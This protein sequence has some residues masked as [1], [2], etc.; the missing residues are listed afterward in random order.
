[1][2]TTRSARWAKKIVSAVVALATVIGV[3][4]VA[5]PSASAANRDNLRPG[6]TWAPSGYWVQNC[7]VYSPAMKTNITVQIQ[8]AARG[9]NAGLYLLDGMRAENTFNAWSTLANAPAT[10]VNDNVTLVMPVGGK[11]SF[12]TDWL[13]P[14]GTRTIKW[15]TFLTQELPAY[16]QQNFGVSPNNN[17][18]GGVSMGA[19][20]AMNLAAHHR[21]QF[22]QVLSMSGYLHTTAPGMYSMINLAMFDVT[23]NPAMNVFSMWGPPYFIGALNNDPWINVNKLKGLDVYASAATGRFGEYENIDSLQ[24]LSIA[25]SGAALEGFSVASTKDWEIRARLA[26]LNAR[27]KYYPNGVHNWPYWNNDLAS[28]RTRVLDVLQA[29]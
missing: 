24:T 22:R 14:A 6:C 13:F 17:S 19:T 3:G 9:G 2:T 1:M 11:A 12:Y 29:W 26:G 10:F 4:A 7:P 15:E 18:I 5:A 25:Y 21:N 23:H 20:A 28:Q 27:V 8:P 16:L